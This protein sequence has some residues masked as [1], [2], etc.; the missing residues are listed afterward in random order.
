MT[1]SEHL[2]SINAP[3]AFQEWASG[4]TAQEAWDTCHRPDWMLY[5]A[6]STKANAAQSIMISSHDVMSCVG[7]PNLERNPQWNGIVPEWAMIVRDT[8]GAD[9]RTPRRVKAFDEWHEW[10]LSRDWHG[11]RFCESIRD[12]RLVIPW[13]EDGNQELAPPFLEEDP[14]AEEAVKECA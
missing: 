8:W 4:K 13:T 9:P 14:I 11:L 7:Y 10:I 1:L 5:W 3:Q 6:A 12:Y 2:S